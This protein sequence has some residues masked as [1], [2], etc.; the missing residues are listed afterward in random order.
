ME[1]NGKER[2]FF[3]KCRTECVFFY[4]FFFLFFFFLSVMFDGGL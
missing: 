3:C 2:L 1:N 4:Y